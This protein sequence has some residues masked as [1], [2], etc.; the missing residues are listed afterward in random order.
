[1]QIFKTYFFFRVVLFVSGFAECKIVTWTSLSLCARQ[2][3]RRRVVHKPVQRPL[4]TGA[5]SASFFFQKIN[6]MYLK[7]VLHPGANEQ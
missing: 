3:P 7:K 1:M 6:V 5:V 2:Q 4:V